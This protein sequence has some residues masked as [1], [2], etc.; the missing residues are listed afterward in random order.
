MGTVSKCTSGGSISGNNGLENFGGLVGYNEQ[1]NIYSCSSSGNLS[2]GQEDTS[3]VGGL[4]GYNDNGNI[5][6]CFASGDI[7]GKDS[8]YSLGG[9]VGTN[10]NS[11]KINNCYSTGNVSSGNGS[12]SI[13]GLVGGN[14]YDCSITN[15]YSTSSI[16]TGEETYNIGGLIG[17][18]DAGDINDCY[19]LD[20]AGPNNG[21]ATP[22]ADSQMKQQA[23]FIGWDFVWETAN[24]PNDVWAICE[25][26]SYPKLA[27]QFIPGDFD[28]N[29]DVNFID[30]S[31]FASE[32]MQTDS[33]LYCGGADLTGDGLID[34][35]DLAVFTQ[36]WLIEI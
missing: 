25:G 36:N 26:V 29:K 15:C 34:I 33:T 30:F 17:Y 5:D 6:R 9:L 1:S 28:N 19:F 21:Y 4:V 27:W 12:D 7:N 2:G 23:S 11:G 10:D 35:T 32:W 8:S 16:T 14:Y 24:G 20:V 18:Y 13:G 22:L 31:T 3:Q